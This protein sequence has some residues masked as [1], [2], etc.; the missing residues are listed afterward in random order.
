M[1]FVGVGGVYISMAEMVDVGESGL[2][3]VSEGVGVVWV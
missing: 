2:L 1:L 3:C